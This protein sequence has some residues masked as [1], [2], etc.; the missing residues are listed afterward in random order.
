MLD[1]RFL[2]IAMII[3]SA[4]FVNACGDNAHG[5]FNS[6]DD[7]ES[8][9]PTTVINL[10]GNAGDG[11]VSLG[12]EAPATGSQP[13]SYT[14]AIEP[15]TVS[16]TITRSGMHA[17]IQGLRNDTTYT[18]AVT[19]KNKVGAS[20]ASTI[21]L[22]PTA[23]DPNAFSTLTRDTT[24]ANSPS[25][26][27]DASLLNTSNTLWMAYS[28]VDYYQLSGHRVQDVSTSLAYSND[29]G[30]SFTYL[31]TIGA[32][33]G[34][35]I[36]PTTLNPCGNTVCNGRWVYE[37]PFL[38]DDSSDPDATRRF[39]LF[40]M[41][42]FLY[43]TA[44]PSTFY[45]LGAIVMW[46]APSPES[47]WSN[48]SVVLSWDSTPQE[49]SPKNNIRN[50]DSALAEC[51]VLSEGS[52]T[53]YGDALDFVF[54]C[55]NRTDLQKIVLLRS[56]DHAKTFKYVATPLEAADA[57]A[58]GAL[59]FSAPALLPSESSAPVLIAT[60]VINRAI[61]GVATNLSAYSGCIVFPFAD[62]ES[63]SLFRASSAPISILQIPY[64]TNHLNGACTWDRGVGASGILMNDGNA[65]ADCAV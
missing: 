16:A 24:D 59:Y 58:F 6:P 30:A 9:A 63:G 48:E 11:A 25:G 20:S 14:I 32:A 1:R 2:A 4:I 5:A 64:T 47:S 44:N 35:T 52:A 34:A 17:L 19:A 42:Y 56:T 29:S 50:I 18:F 53:L 12:W 55:P 10:A 49:L 7:T 54:A 36:T 40:A 33:T 28:S 57:A 31:K 38:V 65:S 8:A 62:E 60:P 3:A 22:K 13:L 39:K 27:F 41:K 15:N 45:A 61:N 26:I 23:I 37:V 51:T 43:P 46:T 21:L